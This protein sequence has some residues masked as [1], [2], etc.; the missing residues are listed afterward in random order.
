[1]FIT[2]FWYSKV[3]FILSYQGILDTVVNKVA[4]LGSIHLFRR[5]YG[6]TKRN[7]LECQR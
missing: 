6:R 2:L 4:S 7:K 1:M 5:S 3:M